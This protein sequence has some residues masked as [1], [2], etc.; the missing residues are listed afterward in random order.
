MLLCYSIIGKHH[1][2]RR[3]YLENIVESACGA[4]QEREVGDLL[5]LRRAAWAPPLV[6]DG[7]TGHEGNLKSAGKT[8]TS[9]SFSS[10]LRLHGAGEGEQTRGVCA[11]SL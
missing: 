5:V 4:V 7:S 3:I 8:L 2:C 9:F 11:V 6:L 1:L 10:P